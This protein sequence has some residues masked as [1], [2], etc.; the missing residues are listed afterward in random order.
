[1]KKLVIS[2]FLNEKE[3]AAWWNKHRR[4][5]EANLRRSMRETT[6]LTMSDVMTR[7]STSRTSPG[8][9]PGGEKRETH[10]TADAAG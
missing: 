10:P 7:A 1:M 6:T 9:E 2:S 8:R 3:E 5:V 4:T